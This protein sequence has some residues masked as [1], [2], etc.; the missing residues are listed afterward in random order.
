VISK[1]ARP[2]VSHVTHDFGSILTFIEHN[3]GL[4]QMGDASSGTTSTTWNADGLAAARGDFLLD[5][6]NFNGNI[7]FTTVSRLD[8]FSPVDAPL[9]PEWFLA[10]RPDIKYPAIDT[11][12]DDE[13]LTPTQQA[14]FERV[15]QHYIRIVRTALHEQETGVKHLTLQ[16]SLSSTML[17]GTKFTARDITGKLFAGHIVTHPSE[18]ETGNV[19]LLLAF[20]DPITVLSYSARKSVTYMQTL[21]KGQVIEVKIEKRTKS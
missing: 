12:M 5:M 6:F 21:H 20:D 14:S 2:G 7:G 11:D 9:P 17:S 10:A 1:Y 19:S 18:H 16:Q 15:R 13:P 3:F 8:H 4:S